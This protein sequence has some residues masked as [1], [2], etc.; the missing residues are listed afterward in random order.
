MNNKILSSA[1]ILLLAINVF[2][3]SY[4][5][6]EK[7]ASL[8]RMKRNLE[9]FASDE[10]EG[11]ETA[12][13]GIRKTAEHIAGIFEECGVMP[14]GDD[15]TYFQNFTLIGTRF[16]KESNIT[17]YDKED[18]LY[19]KLKI[20]ES[21]ISLPNMHGDIEKMNDNYPLV[22]AGFGINAEEY[23]YN[24]FL[25]LDVKD[26]IV[27]VFMG[28]PYSENPDFFDAEKDTKYAG[29]RTKI[30]AAKMFGAAGIILIPDQQYLQY[31]PF[32][33]NMA[34]TETLSRPNENSEPQSSIP[35]AMISID[36]ITEVFNGEESSFDELK[37]LIEEKDI[38]RG[39]DLKKSAAIN[40]SV[41]ENEKNARNVVGIIEGADPVLK[42][43][44]ITIGAHMD[45][46]G[47][48]K[49]EVYN[50]ADDNASGTVG[51]VETTCRL[52]KKGDNKRSIIAILYTAE[53][54]GLIGSQYF[55]ENFE[56]LD[57]II[58][59]INLDMVGRGPVDSIFCIG[60][61]RVSLELPD[62]LN[63][64]NE[65]SAKFYLDYSLSNTRLFM[66]SDHY[67][68]AKQNIPVVFFFDNMTEDLH[69][70]SDDFDKI[71]Y[72]KIYSTT[73]LVEEIVL[74]LSN[75]DERLEI[76]PT[77]E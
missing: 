57:N 61:D 4:S 47:V 49:D 21:V 77:E 5:E 73:L 12:S 39:F 13:E 72:D 43:E 55:V 58:A 48:M 46:V 2:T 3:Q 16:D 45:H 53:E 28:E 24:D 38:P 42:S 27:I 50:G 56:N 20:G 30:E 37:S 10:L 68:F 60:A 34:L 33:S 31:W 32:I 17:I 51:V 25:D 70:P 44:Y 35:A 40:L 22:F 74:M 69:R 11:R 9:Y 52:A 76:N 1:L 6:D 59:N 64:A 8:L 7:E 54:K 36:G 71:N 14:F 19:S 63:E 67:S 15:G 23:Q 62:L 29:F 66:Q 65:K 41:I 18:N 26:K 75:R